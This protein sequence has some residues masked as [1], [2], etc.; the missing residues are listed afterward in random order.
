MDF[1]VK[2]SGVEGC[3][4]CD[5]SP[6][7]CATCNVSYELEQYIG[8]AT[9]CGFSG[10]DGTGGRYTTLDM[11]FDVESHAD[12][13]YGGLPDGHEDATVTG[14]VQFV[15]AWTDSAGGHSAC[16]TSCNATTAFYSRVRNSPLAGNNTSE[17]IAYTCAGQTNACHAIQPNLG[18]DFALFASCHLSTGVITSDP[19]NT[20]VDGTFSTSSSGTQNSVTLEAWTCS[21]AGSVTKQLTG[22]VTVA[23][24][25]NE[26]IQN[27]LVTT[28]EPEES[29]YNSAYNFVEY[30]T[31]SQCGFAQYAR[32]RYRWHNF[33]HDTTCATVKV[34]WVILESD[35]QLIHSEYELTFG[36][37]YSDWID[38]EPDPGDIDGAYELG[39]F[40]FVPA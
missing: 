18:H 4:G 22:E 40:T 35:T 15:N 17:S 23:E 8:S 33:T 28:P 11:T 37:E 3:C 12:W 29:S 26:A 34:N 5:S 25:V 31:P 16:V 7:G 24:V 1:F 32:I 6:C 21:G 13:T 27:S 10:F 14:D 30:G 9:W 2:A 36:G 19:G 38:F 39:P 20:T